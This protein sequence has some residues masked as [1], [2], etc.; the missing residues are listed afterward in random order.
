MLAVRARR[1]EG[2]LDVPPFVV[3]QSAGAIIALAVAP[4]IFHATLA[5]A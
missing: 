2:V 4:K 5:P 1:H 3:A